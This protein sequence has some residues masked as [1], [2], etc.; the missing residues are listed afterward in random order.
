MWRSIFNLI[1]ENGFLTKMFTLWRSFF[2]KLYF[3]FILSK[4]H[5]KTLWLSKIGNFKATHCY[6]IGIIV[7]LT[8]KSIVHTII[9]TFFDHSNSILFRIFYLNHSYFVKIQCPMIILLEKHKNIIEFLHLLKL[10]Q[11]KFVIF[12]WTKHKFVKLR[13]Q[14]CSFVEIK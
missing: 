6:F 3:T 7:W 10:L 5:V 2:P 4:L 12:T 14:L 8:E 9:V 13:Q 11:S 1:I